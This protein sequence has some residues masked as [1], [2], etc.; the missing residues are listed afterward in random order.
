MDDKALDIIYNFFNTI[1]SDKLCITEGGWNM[2]YM[3]AVEKALKM[4]GRFFFKWFCC[5]EFFDKAKKELVDLG[6]KDYIQGD[7]I[8][9][10]LQEEYYV[11]LELELEGKK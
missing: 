9:F 1:T 11:E 4:K 5:K 3:V 2:T 10:C 7:I 8:S 6:H